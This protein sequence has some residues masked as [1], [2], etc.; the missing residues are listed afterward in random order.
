MSHDVSCQGSALCVD[1][2]ALD[3]NKRYIFHYRVCEKG[4]F[5]SPLR[6]LV[7]I[8]SI[9]S[10][11]AIPFNSEA[12]D[13]VF[14]PFIRPN[15]LSENYFGSGDVNDDGKV[16]WDDYDLMKD[17]TSNDY[18][19]VDGDSIT[20]NSDLSL[21]EQHLRYG[22]ILSGDWDNLPD[23]Q[24]RIDW[25][26]NMLKI[27]KTDEIPYHEPYNEDNNEWTWE[28]YATQ[29]YF[30]F[31]GFEYKYKVP[32]KY[33]TD[34]N[35]RFNLPVYYA[36]L[37]NKSHAITC[38]LIGDDPL[39]FYDWYF[40]EPQSDI[41]INLNYWGEYTD[42]MISDIFKTGL[43]S[44]VSDNIVEFNVS[45]ND[46]EINEYDKN[47]ILTRPSN[48]N[49]QGSLETKYGLITNI[50]NPFLRPNVLSENYY[51]SGDVNDDGKV[52][53][54]DHDLM[55]DGTSNDYADVDGD[56][57]CS[58]SSDLLI[59]KEYLTNGTV[60]PGDWNNLQTREQRKDWV[61]KMLHIDKTD[62]LTHIKDEWQCGDFSTQ[63]CLNFFGLRNKYDITSKYNAI[64]DGRF[65]L[66]VYYT[67]SSTPAHPIN[68]ILVGDDPLNLNDWY[69]FEP[70]SDTSINLND[71][72]KYYDT[73]IDVWII[74]G[75]GF[76]FDSL[77]GY[78]IIGFNVSKN[79][80]KV[81]KYH[82]NLVLTRPEPNYVAKNKPI[83]F[84]LKQ[85]Y[86]NPFNETTTIQYQLPENSKVSLDIY[87]I[88]GQKIKT[89]VDKI[90]EPG[91]HQVI[92]NANNVT[93]GIYFYQLRTQDGVKTQ[94]MMLVK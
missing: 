40:F 88:S 73:D 7:S 29:T 83:E 79:D 17:R 67:H 62:E 58:T 22:D 94:K 1:L 35:G 45:K 69:F 59:L 2:Q 30:N 13:S 19:D 23:R 53:W 84:S 56:G 93:S 46:F 49:T 87:N 11:I 6:N 24:S 12:Q 55:K 64:N 20:T 82:E 25:L 34:N 91:L 28:H 92:F 47:L 74:E 39:N 41:E 16:N 50:F 77:R 43:E 32:S 52:N 42:V 76:F 4:L 8:V 68:C 31:F 9:I 70:Q 86:P 80:F 5:H 54:D 38:I 14:N 65:N 85:N 33:N 44:R 71:W 26:N 60:L 75:Y 66:P 10:I 18:A 61:K 57:A 89:L 81:N 36:H 63:I 21:L 78:Y 27:D 90:Q 3:N 15:V 48:L 72:C 37:L 51:G